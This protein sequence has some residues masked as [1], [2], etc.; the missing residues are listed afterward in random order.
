MNMQQDAHKK[1]NNLYWGIEAKKVDRCNFIDN[2]LLLV[3]IRSN[4]S[5]E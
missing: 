3:W 1:Y 2:S 4:T 5:F